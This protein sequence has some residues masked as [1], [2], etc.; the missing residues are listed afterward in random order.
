M[1]D[2][3]R[4]IMSR[5]LEMPIEDITDNASVHNIKSWDS[6]H[7]L[8]MILAFEEE[9]GVSFPDNEVVELLSFEAIIAALDKKLQ[10]S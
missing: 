5:V 2:K 3:V 8:L 10:S 7:H 4:E 1:K 9:F 6:M